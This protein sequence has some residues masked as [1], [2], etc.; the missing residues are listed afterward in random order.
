MAFFCSFSECNGDVMTDLKCFKYSQEIVL[1][2]NLSFC[3]ILFQILFTK[4]A[5][6]TVLL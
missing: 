6:L 1:E 5:L 2:L 3:V 4:C